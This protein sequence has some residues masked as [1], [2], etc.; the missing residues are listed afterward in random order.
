[1]SEV[2]SNVMAMWM[3]DASPFHG[4]LEFAIVILFPGGVLPRRAESLAQQH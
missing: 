3:E 4:V 2:M 1:M